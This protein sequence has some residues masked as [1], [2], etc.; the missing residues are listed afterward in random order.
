[1]AAF[2]RPALEPASALADN[3]PGGRRADDANVAEWYAA[4]AGRNGGPWNADR[5][6]RWRM[7]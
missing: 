2:A 6:A 3:P 4:S 7:E 1:L 5:P